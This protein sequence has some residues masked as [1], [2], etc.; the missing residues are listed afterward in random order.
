MYKYFRLTIYC[1]LLTAYCFTGCKR[2]EETSESAKQVKKIFT[3]PEDGKISPD[4]SDRYISTSRYLMEAIRRHEKEIDNFAQK[5]NVKADLGELSDSTFRKKHPEV[6]AA[7]D[8]VT[9][10]WNKE[11]KSAYTKAGI[12]EDEFNWIGGALTDT[13]NKEIQKDIAER[14]KEIMEVT[15]SE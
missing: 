5:H 15:K 7:W 11:E 9:N 12:S 14:I 8:S 10:E 2:S 4:A 3:P 13:I 1:L 6:T